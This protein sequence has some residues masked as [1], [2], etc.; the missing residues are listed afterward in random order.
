MYHAMAA[1]CWLLVLLGFK[2]RVGVGVVGVRIRR[3]GRQSFS[4]DYF[5]G[6]LSKLPASYNSKKEAVLLDSN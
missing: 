6:Q 2:E 1:G 5:V 3:T 4:F